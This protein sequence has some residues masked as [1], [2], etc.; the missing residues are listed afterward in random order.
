MTAPRAVLA[1]ARAWL[2]HVG[3]P[4][5]FASVLAV[6]GL[7]GVDALSGSGRI[8]VL[9]ALSLAG[10]VLALGTAHG[11]AWQVAQ[12]TV[13]RLPARTRRA[14]WLVV[15]GCAA[16]LLATRLGAFSRLQGR[17]A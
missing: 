8:G 3:S 4:Y 16:G 6:G 10:L 17:Y 5:P 9:F 14:A 2:A 1:R 12:A 15:A 11:L 13:A 7:V